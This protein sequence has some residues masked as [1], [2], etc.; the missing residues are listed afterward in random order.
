MATGWAEAF[1]RAIKERDEDNKEALARILAAITEEAGDDVKTARRI[2]RE[3][4]EADERAIVDHA[5]WIMAEKEQLAGLCVP[6]IRF[7]SIGGE[8]H[9]EPAV[10]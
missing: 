2:L 8:V 10:K 3:R 7:G 5:V 1:K 4:V 9:Q 6:K